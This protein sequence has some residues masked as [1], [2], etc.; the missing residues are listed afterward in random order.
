MK[1]RTFRRCSIFGVLFSPV[2]TLFHTELMPP[3]L[4]V[5]QPKRPHPC[6]HKSLPHPCLVTLSLAWPES[7][8][9]P[10]PPC[11][12]TPAVSLQHQ[13]PSSKDPLGNQASVLSMPFLR[14]PMS[15]PQLVA[16]QP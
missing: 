13:G 3:H 15:A 10:G 4:P 12:I 9:A 8:R 1:S 6:M 14:H 2:S 16:P 7:P 5:Q 11:S